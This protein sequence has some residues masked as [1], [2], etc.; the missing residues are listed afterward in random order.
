VAPQVEVQDLEVLGHQP[1]GEIWHHSGMEI[2]RKQ[3]LKIMAGS[4]AAVAAGAARPAIGLAA[5]SGPSQIIERDVC[6]IGG[7]ASGCYTAVRLGDFGKSVVLVERRDRLGGDCQTY[8][9]PVTGGTTDIGVLIFHDLPIVTNLFSRFNVPLVTYS[10]G[11]A[12]TDYVDFRTGQVV[13]GY[14]PPEPVQLP[15]LLAI[16]EQYPYLEAGWDLP[17]PVPPELLLPW[18]DFLAENGLQSLA[19]FIAQY[20]QGLGDVLRKLTVYVMKNFGI[21]VVT[22]ILQNS[23]LTTPNMDNSQLY[24]N[25]TTYL[26]DDVLLNATITRVDRSNGVLVQ[27]GTPRGAFTIR[28]NTLVIAIPPLLQNLSPFDLSGNERSLLGQFRPGFYY[29]GLL[30]MTGYPA[31]LVVQ[32]TGADTVDNLPPLPGIYSVRPSGLPG[33]FHVTYGS[34]FALSGAQVQANIL[35]DVNRLRTA[36]TVP[37][38]SAEFAIFRNHSPFELTVSKSD[39]AGGFYANLYALQGQRNTFY[40]GAAFHTQDSSLLWQFTETLLPQIVAS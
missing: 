9:D 30:E 32:N 20:T 6:V 23:F 8:L 29:T 1:Q 5:G 11:T 21:G 17:Y 12:T 24:E 15:A 22:N 37:V 13:P 7:G 10:P 28:A 3:M 33:L 31:D 14:A 27:V 2:T 19:P 39:I 25:I 26:G 16:L 36:G 4:G 18:G 40:N 38:S 34:P 35:A